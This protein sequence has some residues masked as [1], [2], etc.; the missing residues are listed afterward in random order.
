M[1]KTT[2]IRVLIADD[3]AVLRAGLRML[4][5]SQLD[6]TVVG[7]AE[8]GIEAMQVAEETKPDVVIL[9]ITMPGSGG[10]H[11]I[12][13]ILKGNPAVHIL[14]L[15]MHEE[16]AYLRTALAAGAS[17]YVLKKSVDADL[18]SAIR[19]VH[20]GR[21]YVDSEMASG[22]LL[23]ALPD[24]GKGSKEVLSERELQVLKLVAEGY[25]SREIAEQIIVG[26]KTVETYRGR[27][28]EKLGLKSRADIVRYALEVGILS[29]EKFSVPDEQ[30]KR[31]IVGKT[32]NKV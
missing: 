28:A 4:I 25:S 27:L 8:N 6:M 32:R 17:G 20:K 2:R 31:P 3:H 11:A 15:T 1:A 23:H 30:K 9:D 18:L 10:L 26:I 29:S 24:R 12:G 19:A 16:P 13:K 22:L 21:T 7:E 14:L 5:N